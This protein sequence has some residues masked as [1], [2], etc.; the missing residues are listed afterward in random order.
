MR[1]LPILKSF[2]FEILELDFSGQ[3]I[4]GDRKKWGRHL[5]FEYFLQTAVG[6]VVTKNSNLVL[7]V[8]RRDEKRKPLNVIPVDV[9]NQQT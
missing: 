6:T 3:I 8:V 1:T 5:P 7:V 2:D 4:Q 9:S